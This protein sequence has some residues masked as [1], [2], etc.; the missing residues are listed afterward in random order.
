MASR[1]TNLISKKSKLHVQHTFFSNWLK[2]PI[3]YCFCLVINTLGW[4]SLLPSFLKNIAR[5][6][7]H[8]RIQTV[9]SPRRYSPICKCEFSLKYLKNQT[10]LT[11]KKWKW[12]KRHENYRFQ[13]CQPLRNEV[14]SIHVM[15]DHSAYS[16]DVFSSFIAFE[17]IKSANRK[18]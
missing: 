14:Y 4:T 10:R 12:W 18:T 11:K 16:S 17:E 1:S 8:G 2:F 13:D 9:L 7:E 3:V 6:S 5:L 15:S